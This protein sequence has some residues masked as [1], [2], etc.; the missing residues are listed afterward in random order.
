MTASGRTHRLSI[1][2]QR[3]CPHGRRSLLTL[4]ARA[5]LDIPHFFVRYKM[6]TVAGCRAC[7]RW[8]TGS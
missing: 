6:R 4:S 1:L 8:Q 2:W 3:C 7:W 5:A